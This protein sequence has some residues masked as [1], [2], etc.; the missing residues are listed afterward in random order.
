M[1]K[2]Q[3]NISSFKNGLDARR[4]A[5][6]LGGNVLL[7]AQDGHITQ[8]GDFEKRKGFFEFANTAILDTNG[9]TGCFGLQ[10][11]INGLYR[12]GSAIVYGGSVTLS[13]P[14]LASAMPT[15]VSYQQL[16][17][18]AIY[19]G[20]TY[21][22]TK[23]RMTAVVTNA[24]TGV[25]QAIATFA[26]G[27]K[28]LYYNGNLVEEI[29]AGNIMAHLS[30]NALIAKNLA[31]VVNAT[32]DKFTAAYSGSNTYVDITSD[33][34]YDFESQ[35]TK[36]STSGTM[37][38][39]TTAEATSAIA[40]VEP[41]A[42]FRIIAGEDN[43]KA[44]STLTNDGTA[45]A[46]GSSVTVGGITYT[47]KTVISANHDVLIGNTANGDAA[48][49]NL[50]SAI[51]FTGVAGTDYVGTAANPQV[52]TDA[53][54]TGANTLKVWA[55]TP[56][57]G[58]N[59]IA[60]T[61]AGTSHASWTGATLASG[62]D[63]NKI[64]SIR[65]GGSEILGTA[66]NWITNSNTTATLVATQINAY[67]SGYTAEASGDTVII[68]APEG[69]TT[70]NATALTVT[71]SGQLCVGDFFAAFIVGGAGFTIANFNIDAVDVKGAMGGGTST[72]SY[73]DLATFCDALAVSITNVGT[74]SAVAVG[75]VVYV[76]KL[77]TTSNDIPLNAYVTITPAAAN[78]G[79]GVTL[80]NV[81]ADGTFLAAVTPS[82]NVAKTGEPVSGVGGFVISTD[83][84]TVVP[85]F[86][87]APYSYNWVKQEGDP[88]VNPWFATSATTFFYFNAGVSFVKGL[89]AAKFICEITDS[90]GVKA[91][92]PLVNVV[93]T[94]I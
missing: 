66:V 29:T 25:A 50:A 22:R 67:A 69:G 92:T 43:A 21:D 51:S 15:G 39:V 47:W 18:P 7:T 23:H 35:I 1:A 49:T 86:G 63:T 84:V 88:L 4:D 46:N 40:A 93:I 14:T 94:Y 32:A 20:T 26:D 36:S 61:T 54:N 12:F 65:A 17:H 62:A 70:L 76:G 56:G 53:Y 64:T 74:Y 81:P 52:Y 45:P 82:A 16:K 57:T 3:I 30:T 55:R 6:V 83:N 78:N 91:N 9:D 28:Y 24:Y 11:T 10:D 73:A 87:V 2:K 85:Y 42:K 44:F 5:L 58:G 71:V 72:G 48:M 77:V 8:G 80:G 90:K 41:K 19:D 75:N 89:H 38:S 59:S 79:S 37:V 60:T 13:Q 27:K 68:T 34:G 33:I 31:R